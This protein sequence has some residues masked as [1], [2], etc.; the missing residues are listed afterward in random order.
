M[1]VVSNEGAVGQNA[2]VPHTKIKNKKVVWLFCILGSDSQTALPK[3]LS[4]VN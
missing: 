1:L 4:A 2:N 3:F